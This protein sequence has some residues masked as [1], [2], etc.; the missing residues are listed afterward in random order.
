MTHTKRINNLLHLKTFRKKLRNHL[1]PAE[2]TLWKVLKNKGLEGKKFRRQHRVGN[3][4]LDFYCPSERLAVELDGEVH[5]N[6][7]AK[8]YDY[9]RKLL[10]ARYGIRVLRFENRLVFEALGWMLD[11]I[12]RNFGW[13]RK[14]P[15]PAGTPP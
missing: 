3:Y 11:V 4:I 14:P 10:L 12:S 2:A 15:R 8:E 13:H 7:A 1:T 9:E 6:D 5:M